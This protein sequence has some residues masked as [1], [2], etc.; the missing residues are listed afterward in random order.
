M[1]GLSYGRSIRRAVNQTRRAVDPKGGL[2]PE[3]CPASIR[4]ENDQ[5]MATA[6]DTKTN[7]VILGNHGFAM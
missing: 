4:K 3:V 7:T 1:D 5:P 2:L 6:V